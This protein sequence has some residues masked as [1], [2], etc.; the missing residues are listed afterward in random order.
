MRLWH[1]RLIQFIPDYK[2]SGN[3]K[4]NQL[5]GQWREVKAI[6]GTIIKRGKLNQS[7]VNYI[8]DHSLDHLRAY[9]LAIAI[10]MLVRGYSIDPTIVKLYLTQ[11]ALD[12]YRNNLISLGCIYPEHNS[13]Y[14]IEC[15]NNLNGKGIKLNRITSFHDYRNTYVNIYGHEFDLNEIFS[16]FTYKEFVLYIE[17]LIADN[18]KMSTTHGTFIDKLS[19]KISLKSLPMYLY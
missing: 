5:A 3:K 2:S 16:H 15:V 7:V 13:K 10:E 11:E 17:S 12:I 9:G 19:K 4:H 6:Y 8:N 14:L 1:E 18:M